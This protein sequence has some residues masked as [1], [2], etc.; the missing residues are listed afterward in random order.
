MVTPGP[1]S[2]RETRRETP[3]RRHPRAPGAPS[4]E[5]MSAS[6]FDLNFFRRRLLR[7]G[8]PADALVRSSEMPRY[9]DASGS[10]FTY[11]YVI[12]VRPQNGAPFETELR[13]AFSAFLRPKPGDLVKVR[14]NPKSGKV[15]FDLDGD[16]RYDLDARPKDVWTSDEPRPR[17]AF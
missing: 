14:W 1:L 10:F 6:G 4:I 11:D 12:E 8:E 16:P 2:G 3:V 7:H 5:A 15:A 13:D 9:Q 17:G